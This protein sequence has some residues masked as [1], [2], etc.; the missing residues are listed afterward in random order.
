MEERLNPDSEFKTWLEVLPKDYS[1]FPLMYKP[2]EI[3]YLEG[4]QIFKRT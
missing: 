3:K 1:T 4:S 2:N